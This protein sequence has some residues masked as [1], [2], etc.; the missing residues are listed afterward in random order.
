MR[1]IMCL[2]PW[3]YSAACGVAL[4]PDSFDG[5]SVFKTPF[6]KVKRSEFPEGRGIFVQNGRTA[7]V[8]LPVA[9]G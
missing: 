7:T 1:R 9:G 8:H 5:D 6:P 2:R 4:R 3:S